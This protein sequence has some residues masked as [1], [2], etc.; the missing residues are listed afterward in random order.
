[1]TASF[2]L[3]TEALAAGFA[4]AR[5]IRVEHRGFEIVA[6]DCSGPHSQGYR[7]TLAIGSGRHELFGLDAAPLAWK[8]RTYSQSVWLRQE[9]C[10]IGTPGSFTQMFGPELD[11]GIA[12][13]IAVIDAWVDADPGRRAIVEAQE[14]AEEDREIRQAAKRQARMDRRA[15]AHAQ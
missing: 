8:S 14:Q 6:R 11:E 15:A 3:R 7:Y 10:Q 13:G 4:P 5:T 9:L 12:S 1:M 2:N